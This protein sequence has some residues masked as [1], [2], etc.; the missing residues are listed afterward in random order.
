MS[1]HM[2]EQQAE[3]LHDPTGTVRALDCDSLDTREL[4]RRVRRPVEGEQMPESDLWRAYVE[5]ARRGEAGAANH[6][7]RSLKT[8]HR[9]RAM[10][11][12]HLGHD[13]PDPNEH[14]LAS[15]PYL[16]ELWKAYKRCISQNRPGPASQLLRDLE[17]QLIG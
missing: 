17:A 3:A 12:G 2:M 16:G 11:N 8:L 1:S 6:F 4:I 14:R 10:G 7:M 13:D 5:L 9:R 15:D